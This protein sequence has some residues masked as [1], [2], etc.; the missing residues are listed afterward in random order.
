MLS[1]KC[2]LLYDIGHPDLFDTVSPCNID[3]ANIALA[4]ADHIDWDM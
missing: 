3:E 1:Y 2:N 4:D